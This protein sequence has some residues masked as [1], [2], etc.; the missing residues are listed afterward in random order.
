LKASPRG[1]PS[2]EPVV[3]SG[4]NDP[5]GTIPEGVCTPSGSS[6]AP[7]PAA[8]RTRSRMASAARCT[9]LPAT[10]VPA[11]P[12]APVSYPA[13]SVSDERMRTRSGAM[14]RTS[15]TIWLCTVVVPFP[16][17]AVPT[18]SDAHPSGSSARRT[19]LKWPRGGI[20]AIMPSAIPVPVR[21]SAPSG[22]GSPGSRSADLA[23]SSASGSP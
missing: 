9:A 6:T 17:S 4:A 23:S 5:S 21:H 10:T 18:S 20:V 15:A 14:A 11:E 12:N 1:V 13:P 19:S 2:A 22:A 16:N 7:G 3:V 8:V